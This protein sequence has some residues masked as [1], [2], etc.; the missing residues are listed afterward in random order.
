MPVP[1]P[2]VRTSQRQNRDCSDRFSEDVPSGAYLHAYPSE[3]ISP[4]YTRF[5]AAKRASPLNAVVTADDK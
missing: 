4:Y 1:Y 5:E 2:A 3:E